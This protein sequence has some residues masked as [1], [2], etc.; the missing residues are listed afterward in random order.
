MCTS[1][2]KSYDHIYV[3]SSVCGTL[4]DDVDEYDE[5]HKRLPLHGICRRLFWSGQMV[6]CWSVAD[7]GLVFV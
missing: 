6:S 1:L 5:P 7:C 2:F 3:S 4:R